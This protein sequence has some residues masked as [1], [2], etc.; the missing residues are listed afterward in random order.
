MTLQNAAVGCPHGRESLARHNSFN[1]S[2]VS[3]KEKKKHPPERV[4]SRK[5]KKKQQ[6]SLSKNLMKEPPAQ[7][8]IQQIAKETA[9][10]KAFKYALL[11]IGFAFV[12]V[13]AV[14]AFYRIR[15]PFE[16]E[17][18]EGGVLEHVNRILL[19]KR[20][21]VE[22]SLDFISFVY[23]P[24]YYY[25]SAALA[26]IV[27]FGFLP[28][29]LISFLATAG[30]LVFIY[31]IVRRE[32]GSW[33][34]AVLAAFLFAAMY[35]LSGYWFDLARVDMLFLFFLLPALYLLRFSVSVKSYFVAGIFIALSF[36]TKQTTLVIAAPLA[37]YALLADKKS[38]GA[39]LAS[40]A[41]ISALVTLLLN[42][43][44][45][46]WYYY[47]VFGI[48]AKPTPSWSNFMRFW[49]SDLLIP[50]FAASALSAFFL[51]RSFR[52][53]KNGFFFYA[54]MA[55]GMIGAAWL[56]RMHNETVQ[57][58]LIPADAAIAILFGSGLHMALRAAPAR[59][60]NKAPEARIVLYALCIIQ[61]GV[62][63]YNPARQLPTKKDI[64]A[65]KK[66]VALIQQIDGEVF[67][68]Y[69]GYLAGFAGK[70]NYAHAMALY[71]YLRCTDDAGEYKMV[72]SAW[73]ALHR[74]DFS[75]IVLDSDPYLLAWFNN[76]LPE[77]YMPKQEIFNDKS[78]FWTRTGMRTRPETV[79]LPKPEKPAFGF[80]VYAPQNH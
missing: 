35:R 79:Y 65:G 78:V 4:V 63:S 3:T 60:P 23:P 31:L 75:A 57:N 73:Q 55:A 74:K 22:P 38:C 24:V 52:E 33:F 20:L 30:T 18:M 39:F 11:I 62:L 13:F 68:P 7:P 17:W 66:V 12:A 21:Y 16:L 53:E 54:A 2:P 34:P 44:Y 46:G 26:K 45:D 72:R 15:Y 37:V 1:D 6:K 61:F 43:S 41:G 32:T 42:S 14:V 80:P 77:N 64:E 10:E 58:V 29:R 25:I 67:F 59:F 56:A 9:I 8:Q 76:L 40:A 50:L 47:Y 69:H 28:L 5:K 36:L 71:D 19:G 51:Y 27:G 49:T 70:R 48:I